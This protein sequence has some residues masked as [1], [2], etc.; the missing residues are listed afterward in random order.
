[1]SQIDL[2]LAARQQYQDDEVQLDVLGVL[3]PGNE[4]LQELQKISIK[5]VYSLPY[6]KRYFVLI[7][8][9]LKIKQLVKLLFVVK[10]LQINLENKNLLVKMYHRSLQF[11][12][13]LNDQLI[14][15]EKM[16]IKLP[17]KF[18]FL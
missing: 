9:G 17:L 2:L 3:Q 13:H 7:I 1:M 14:L 15:E 5:V 4:F 18:L 10:F 8:Y 16:M 6:L 11:V 12:K